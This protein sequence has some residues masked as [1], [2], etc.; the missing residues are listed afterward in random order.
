MGA[1]DASGAALAEAVALT[2]GAALADA[3]GVAVAVGV[4]ALGVVS[5]VGFLSSQAA[6]AAKR[7]R[8]DAERRCV[9]SMVDTDTSKE[10]LSLGAA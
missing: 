2:E 8:T 5:V 4:V 10:V 7:M 1:A 3:L 9:L 6:D